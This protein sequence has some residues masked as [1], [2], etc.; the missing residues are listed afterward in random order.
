MSDP[1]TLTV[2]VRPSILAGPEDI[3]V[4]QG[5]RATFSVVPQGT[6]PFI[7]R[8]PRNNAVIPGATGTVL[9]IDPAFFSDAGTYSVEISSPYGSAR[10]ESAILVVRVLPHRTLDDLTLGGGVVGK[11]PFQS[12][13]APDSIVT[14]SA[15]PAAGWQFLDWLGSVDGT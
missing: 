10:S 2:A 13:F 12:S 6:G 9:T 11:N 8:W 4:F 15:Q 1:A 14:L 7:I 5:E 3:T